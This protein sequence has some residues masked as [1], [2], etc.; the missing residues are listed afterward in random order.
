MKLNRTS[1][2]FSAVTFKQIFKVL[3]KNP[4]TATCATISSH[5]SAPNPLRANS[6]NNPTLFPYIL[7]HES[8]NNQK[9]YLFDWPQVPGGTLPVATWGPA[10]WLTGPFTNYPS[11]T[12]GRRHGVP[13][14]GKWGIIFNVHVVEDLRFL[15][16]IFSIELHQKSFYWKTCF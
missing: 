8:A 12:P 10:A 11:D 13:C 14:V 16:I 4:S 9:T 15:K 5:K 3:M 7:S 2:K 6:K 1:S